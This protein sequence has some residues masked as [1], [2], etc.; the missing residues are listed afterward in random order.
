M[1]VCLSL[2]AK[3]RQKRGPD[4]LGVVTLWQKIYDNRTIQ[5]KGR[6]CELSSGVLVFIFG[7]QSC[8][9]E[10]VKLL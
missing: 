6:F 9:K 10:L 2:I 8:Y 3:P 5:Q 4:P 1:M 7:L